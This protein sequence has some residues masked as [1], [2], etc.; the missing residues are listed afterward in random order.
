MRF[1]TIASLLIA[2][3]LAGLAVYGAQNWLDLERQQF[4]SDLLQRQSQAEAEAKPEN[5]IVV[6]NEAISFGERIDNTKVREIAWAGDLKPEGSFDTV[7]ALVVGTT[8]DTARFALTSMAPGEPI[9]A[10]KVTDPG[11]RAK[12]STAL[13]P[14]KKAISIRVNDV[15]GVAG[16]VLPGDRVDIL[17]TRKDGKGGSF[18]DVLLQGVKVLAIDQIADDR[19]DKPSV[20]R[21]VTFEVDTSEAQKLVLASNVGTLSLALRN[22][23]SN[24][25]EAN[26]RITINDLNEFDVA[27]DLLQAAVEEQNS[28]TEEADPSLERIENIEMLLKNLSDGMAEQIRGVEQKINE[29]EPVIVEREVIKEVVVE[30]E[31]QPIVPIIPVKRTV[32]VIRNGTRDE[33]KVDANNSENGEE[34]ETTAVPE[35]TSQ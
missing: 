35:E 16:F 18:V 14:G 6:A 3:I 7:D 5:T 13:S 32:G 8:E 19:K 2:V 29:Q 27:E 31:V 24:D 21:T 17:L 25:I 9:L 33:Y 15:L 28:A 34:E 10:S 26:E 30:K 1:S 12:L 20:V 11:Q 23:A 4:A 22:V